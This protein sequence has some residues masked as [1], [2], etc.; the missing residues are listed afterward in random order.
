[1]ALSP[2]I[3]HLSTYY[4]QPNILK[5]A[6]QREESEI[7]ELELACTSKACP[8]IGAV[9]PVMESKGKRDCRPK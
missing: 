9:F 5:Q 7:E 3:N 2:V 1:M 8:T 6:R 4:H